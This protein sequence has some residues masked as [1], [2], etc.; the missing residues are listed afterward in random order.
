MNRK[1]ED[2]GERFDPYKRFVKRST[3]KYCSDCKH[4]RMSKRYAGDKNE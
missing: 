2:C 1:C 4:K 3:A